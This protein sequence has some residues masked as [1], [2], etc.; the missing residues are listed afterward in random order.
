MFWFSE[1]DGSI[2]KGPERVGNFNWSKFEWGVPYSSWTAQS[3]AK[4]PHLLPLD[5]KALADAYSEKGG[6]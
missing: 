5:P 2:W 4:P 1:L 3:S 6:E